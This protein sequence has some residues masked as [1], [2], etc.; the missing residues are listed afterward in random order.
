MVEHIE[1]TTRIGCSVNCIKY[2]PQEVITGKYKGNRLMTLYQFKTILRSVPPNIMVCFA[3]FCEPFLNPEA[4]DMILHA[5][6][7][8]HKIQLFTTL[9][10]FTN[11]DL[12]RLKNIPFDSV[13]IHL[14]DSKGCAHI[15]ITKEY[16]ELL[17]KVLTTWDCDVMSMGGA[18][19]TNHRE[20]MARGNPACNKTFPVM[21]DKLKVRQNVVLPNGDVVFCCCDYGLDAVMGNLYV[22]KYSDLKDLYTPGICKTC[23]L[24][25]AIPIYYLKRAIIRCVKG[26]VIKNTE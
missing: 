3:G 21:C 9:V 6:D 10:G 8:G 16:Q 23:M 17:P 2:C 20:D 15:P 14:P 26:L 12:E 19:C 7:R 1:I 18:F 25:D 22:Q 5:H 24:S 4:T 13:I 11:G